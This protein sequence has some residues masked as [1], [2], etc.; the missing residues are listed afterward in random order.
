M[1]V[2]DLRSIF[3]FRKNPPLPGCDVLFI[4]SPANFSEPQGEGNFISTQLNPFLVEAI[5]Q[6]YRVHNVL[7]PGSGSLRRKTNFAVTSFPRIAI[8]SAPGILL[9]WLC[10]IFNHSVADKPS[11]REHFRSYL[12]TWKEVLLTMK[13]KILIGIGLRE[14]VLREAKSLGIY[15]IEVQHGL[16][17][18]DWMKKYWPQLVPDVFFVWDEHTAEISNGLGIPAR[19]TGHPYLEISRTTTFGQ[20]ASGN[21]AVVALAYDSPHTADPFGCMP[22]D[23]FVLA[24][25]I[26]LEG[27]ELIFRIHP[28]IAGERPWVTQMLGV[29]VLLHFPR[30]A[31]SNPLKS[32]VTGLAEKASFLI[33]TG[34]S[35]AFEFGVLSKVSLVLDDEARIRFRKN[36]GPPER[37]TYLIPPPGIWPPRLGSS[38]AYLSTGLVEFTGGDE[39]RDILLNIQTDS[40]E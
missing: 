25:K 17:T 37:A 30:G 21:L 11:L 5:A 13:P 26:Y 6:G 9:S 27:Y 19:V 2:S 22:L 32:P 28:T 20:S 29:W 39:L 8:S 34:S 4:A 7:L 1:K 12:P 35:L 16:L 3:S 14:E 24:R 23:L 40:S 38:D 18:G 33:T 31:I 10:K 15:S 36:L